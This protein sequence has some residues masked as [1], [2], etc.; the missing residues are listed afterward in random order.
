MASGSVSV[1]LPEEVLEQLEKLAQERKQK[2]SDVVRELIISGLKSGTDNGR[3]IEYLEGFGGV[4]MAM[5]FECAASRY[6]GEMATSYGIDME[7]LMR[8][9]KPLS[10]EAKEA[11]MAKFEEAAIRS[12][13]QTWARV[14]NMPQAGEPPK[15]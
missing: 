13:Q 5:V 2:V 15:S 4:L 12:G 7:S 9:G 14:L 11:L 1:R 8:E 3:V 10:K 6:F